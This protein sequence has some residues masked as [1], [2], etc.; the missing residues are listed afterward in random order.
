MYYL[1]LQF[2]SPLGN[3]FRRYTTQ[4]MRDAQRLKSLPPKDLGMPV[5]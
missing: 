2:R 4:G 3:K 1:M 5:G